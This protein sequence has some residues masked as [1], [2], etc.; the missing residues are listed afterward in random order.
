MGS[1]WKKPS[2]RIPDW[3]KSL[4][5]PL[6]EER[7]SRRDR[8]NLREGEP[9]CARSCNSSRS[10]SNFSSILRPGSSSSDRSNRTI[11]LAPCGQAESAARKASRPVLLSEMIV[12][13]AE[14]DVQRDVGR[15]ERVLRVLDREPPGRPG[16]RVA[17]AC[18]DGAEQQ[19]NGPGPVAGAGQLVALQE[20][21]RTHVLG[22]P[23]DQELDDRATA[24]SDRIPQGIMA[25]FVP[26]ADVR[27]GVEQGPDD[28]VVA[29]GRRHDQRALALAVPR[30]DV[31]PPGEQD[32]HDLGGPGVG[33]ELQG[34]PAFGPP[35]VDAGTMVQQRL[36]DRGPVEVRRQHERGL[37]MGV[38]LIDV[39]VLRQETPDDEPITLLRGHVQREGLGRREQRT[40]GPHEP[41]QPHQADEEGRQAGGPPSRMTLHGL[42]DGRERR[43]RSQ[44]SLRLRHDRGGRGTRVVVRGQR[45]GRIAPLQPL[46]VLLQLASGL[47]AMR[48]GLLQRR[49]TTASSLADDG[50]ARDGGPKRP[51][52]SSPVRSSYSTTPTA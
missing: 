11:V 33:G 13:L 42:D 51:S 40:A 26:G 45:L 48:R 12:A 41:C 35:G 32:G 7:T 17:L 22:A 44:P 30:V 9:P 21:E 36:D 5:D 10:S 25:R 18:L 43:R 23:G 24:A 19:G 28:V 38:S 4:R 50:T 16:G 2:H 1:Y 8:V 14:Q 47:V 6:P 15:G 27:A 52:G 20:R 39:R 37:P 29:A 49:R 31:G 3:V 46:E 34:R